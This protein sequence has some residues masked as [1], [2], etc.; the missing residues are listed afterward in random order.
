MGKSVYETL[1]DK[2]VSGAYAAGDPLFETTLA[3]EMGVSRTPIREALIHLMNAGLVE[4]NGRAIVVTSPSPEEILEVYEVRIFVEANAARL[5]A[6][7]HTDL[8]LN[9][10]IRANEELQKCPKTDPKQQ[11]LANQIFHQQI[12]LA[13]HN[14]KIVE[15]LERM[16]VQFQR[17]TDSTFQYP[18]RWKDILVEHTAL[19]EAIA[20]RDADEAARIASEHIDAARTV[21]LKMYEPTALE[22]RYA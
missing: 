21:R 22:S 12:W 2:I 1:R 6:Q 20:A 8:D 4:R 16:S 13:S 11:V 17:Y 19:T 18:G 3:E 5:A 7:R 15:I 10:I 9:R 14:S